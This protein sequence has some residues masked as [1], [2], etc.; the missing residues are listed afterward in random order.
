M[1]VHHVGLA[2]REA[3]ALADLYDDLL[4]AEVAHRERYDGLELW[5]LDVGGDYLELL[6]PVGD[7]E[8]ANYLDRHGPGVHHVAFGTP[9]IESALDRARSA[10][11]SLVD[12]EPRD[13]GRGHRVAFLHP[14]ST[15]GVLIEFVEVEGT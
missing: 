7:G 10:G 13:G 9:T 6:E 12:E 14:N 15:G 5:Y 1:D 3:A 8:V 4:G 2:T 11:V